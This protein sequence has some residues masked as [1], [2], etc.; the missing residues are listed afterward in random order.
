MVVVYILIFILV[1]GL[2]ICFHELGHYFWAKKYGILVNEFAFGMG[3]KLFSKKKGETYWSIRAFPIGGFCA[4]SGE[5]V[6]D[7]MLNPGDKV[8]LVLDDEKKVTKIVMSLDLEEYKDIETTTV[9]KAD[10]FGKDMAPLY[11]NNLEVKR[12]AVVVVGKTENQIAPE[13]RNFFTKGVWKRFM[14][15][16]GGPLNNFILGL[17][18]FLLMAFIMGVPNYKTNKVNEVSGP[19]AVAG[20]Q[21]NDSIIKIGDYEITTENGFGEGAGSISNAVHSTTDRKLNITYTRDNQEYNTVVYASYV[22]NAL[23]FASYSDDINDSNYQELK[24]MVQTKAALGG[25]NKTKAYQALNGLRNGDII[26]KITYYD[27]DNLSK[28]YEFNTWEELYAFALNDA[29]EGGSVEVTY[30]RLDTESNTYKEYTTGKY[31][32][33]SEKVLSSQGYEAAYKQIG[34]GAPSK[35]SFFGSIWNGIKYFGKAAGTI[36]STLWLLFTSKEVGIKDMGGFITILNQ[37]ATYAAGGFTSLLYF[38]GLLSVNLGIVNLLPIPALDGGRI[39]FLLIEGIFKKKINPKVETIIVNVVFWALMA[40][41]L[42]I[43]GQDIFRLIIQL[44]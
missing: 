30:K 26:L 39:L 13:E 34:V 42:F 2:V 10:L 32:I 29:K 18:V 31:N 4:M 35:F 15:C 28:T 24:V 37:T 5:E 41:I 3:P 43:L 27:N 12:D 23:G 38:I 9:E 44:R 17:F 22:F 16:L 25:T 14:V 20:I 21:K 19:A 11:I 36:F 33:Y 6:T 7:S 1:L 40:F 8:K